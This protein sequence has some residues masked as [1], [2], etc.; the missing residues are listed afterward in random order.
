MNR[1]ERL[2][3]ETID[4]TKENIEGKIGKRSV[5]GH[6]E[7]YSFIHDVPDKR[8]GRVFLLLNFFSQ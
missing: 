2:S 4:N 6:I 7:G 3:M 5:W 1:G 8:F